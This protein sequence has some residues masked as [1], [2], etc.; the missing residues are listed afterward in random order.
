MTFSEENYLKAI[1]H[2]E[3]QYEKGVPTNA[4]ADNMDTKASSVT[5]MV[6]RLSRKKLL[7]YKKYQGAKLNEEG[8]KHALNV[9]RKHRLWECFLVD[10]LHFS[11]DE[12]HVIAEQLEHIQ[13]EKLTDKLEVFLGFPEV[14]PHG[15]PIPD[16][17][18]KFAKISKVLLSDC[19]NGQRGVFTGVKDSSVSFL[20]YLDKR[21]IT[22]GTV[23]TVL[24][25]EEFDQSR[26]IENQGQVQSISYKTASNLYLKLLPK[27]GE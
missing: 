2:L 1:F 6:K 24:D 19:E 15:D 16:K 22:L 14:D 13:S 12:V 9:I 27:D 26:K 17:Q 20:Q 11:W 3:H 8:R 4:I 18:G 10:K 25:T 5:D 7:A 23:L 21:A